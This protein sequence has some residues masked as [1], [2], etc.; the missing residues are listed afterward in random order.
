MDNEKEIRESKEKD[1]S[2][3]NTVGDIGNE[4]RLCGMLGLARKAGAIAIGTFSATEALKCN[5]AG[6]LLLAADASSNTSNRAAR[7]CRAHNAELYLLPVGKNRLGACIGKGSDVSTVALT[8]PSF[9]K[10]VYA[11]CKRVDPQIFTAN[12]RNLTQEV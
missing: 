10:T 3:P 12:K 1:S 4:T 9:A 6:A 8:N 5:K 11:M 7:A 2:P